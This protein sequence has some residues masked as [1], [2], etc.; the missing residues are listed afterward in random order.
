MKNFTRNR[1][2]SFKHLILFI[3]QKTNLSL[4]VS[5][6]DFF[7]SQDL[8]PPTKSAFSQARKHLSFTIFKK[9]NRLIAEVFYS[10]ANYKKWKG[11]RVLAVDGSTLKLPDHHSLGEKFSRHGFG[12]K[13]DAQNW[14]S[15]ISYLYDVFNGVV[16]DAQMESFRTSEATLCQYH[17]DW[18]ENGDLLLF[19]RYYASHKLMFQLIGKGAHFIMRMKDNWWKC[20]EEFAQ[21]NLTEQI[22]TLN[23]P[24]KYH[25]LLEQYPHLSTAF[26][27]RL[28]K[29]TKRNGEKQVYVTSLVD[30][31][32][33]STKAITNLY[34]ERWGVEE[35]YKLIKSRLEVADFSGK[36]LAAVLQDFY[37]KTM[38]ISLSNA[39]CFNANPAAVK[40]KAKKGK[41]N[42]GTTERAVIINRSYALNR[43]KK[44]IK[45][46]I[47][48]HSIE[49]LLEEFARKM[50]KKIEYSRKGQYNQRKVNPTIKYSMNYKSI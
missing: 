23:L 38:L 30:R 50:V 44:L 7:E 10:H 9:L 41:T 2:L 34:K 27:V 1:C 43:T 45:S 29:K 31:D 24:A 46:L 4:Q 17:L 19:D 3:L 42:Q 40:P 39:L 16:I 37:A 6:D 11:Y 25:D 22:V 15:R 26:Q 14:M 20:A 33:Y 32:S 5:L 12:P 8:Q 28:V 47:T 35:A 21:S 48:N 49:D 36:T 18:V 13:A